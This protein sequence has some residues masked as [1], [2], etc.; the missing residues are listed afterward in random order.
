LGNRLVFYGLMIGELGLVIALS[1]AI[2]RLSAFAAPGIKKNELQPHRSK[3]WEIPPEGNA[4]FVF[5][6]L[7]LVSAPYL[8]AGNDGIFWLK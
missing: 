4:A 7:Y 1:A 2:N 5:P 8:G 3:Y 6:Q